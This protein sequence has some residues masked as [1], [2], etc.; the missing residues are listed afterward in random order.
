MAK[1]HITQTMLEQ[2][3]DGFCISDRSRVQCDAISTNQGRADI[4]EKLEKAG[5]VKRRFK[6]LFHRY[7]YEITDAGRNAI[8]EPD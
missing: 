1:L 2:L 4:W 3:K 8:A 5:L 7:S 6:S